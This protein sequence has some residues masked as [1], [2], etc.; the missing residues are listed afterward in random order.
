MD[1]QQPLGDSLLQTY[2]E[3]PSALSF[4]DNQ[5]TEHQITVIEPT[6]QFFKA[7]MQRYNASSFDVFVNFNG[8]TV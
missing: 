6:V 7:A 8:L 1:G 2:G 4:S 3:E 5:I